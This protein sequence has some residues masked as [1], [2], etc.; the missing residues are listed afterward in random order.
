MTVEDTSEK[1][2]FVEEGTYKDLKT[3]CGWGLG[4]QMEDV[5]ELKVVHLDAGELVCSL[6][7]GASKV[8]STH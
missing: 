8:Q 2:L 6:T 7:P 1:K 5:N 4:G 3:T